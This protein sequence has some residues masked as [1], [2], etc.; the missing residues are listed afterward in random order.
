MKSVYVCDKCG[1]L[2]NDSYACSDHE[3]GHKMI[4]IFPDYYDGTLSET[5]KGDSVMSF[6]ENSTVPATIVLGA[7]DDWNE[8][9]A[10][11]YTYK[12][13]SQHNVLTNRFN[14]DVKLKRAAEKAEADRRDQSTNLM[15]ADLQEDGETVGKTNFWAVTEQYQ[16]RYGCSYEDRHP[17]A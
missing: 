15:I 2:F 10:K 11:L 5:I 9:T 1:K 13:V 8:N 4:N 12:L 14:D 17:K 16:N 6:S 7:W 3:N